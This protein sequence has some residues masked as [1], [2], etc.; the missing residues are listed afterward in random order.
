[1]SG[2]AYEIAALTMRFWFAALMVFLLWRIIR[3]VLRDYASQRTARRAET[4][5]SLGM[6]EVVSPEVDERGRPHPL[7]GRRFAL[8]RENRIGRARGADIRVTH[9]HVAPYQASI[10]Q[11]GNRVLLSDLGGKNGVLL[12][13]EPVTEDTPLVDGDEITV[14]DAVFVL[15]LMS[16]HHESR[17]EQPRRVRQEVEEDDPL[18]IFDPSEAEP[19]ED[20][21]GW[22][23]GSPWARFVQE[24]DEYDSNADE[25]GEDG[26]DALEDE[27]EEEKPRRR[28]RWRR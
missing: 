22:E 1:V 11:K 6:L 2:S 28:R 21:Q 27:N 13:G 16:A 26:F 23:E 3:A 9:G 25:N 14:G 18:V 17:A 15:H 8:K 20:E 19:E 24:Q 4:G 7:Y 10:F 5:Y 12:N